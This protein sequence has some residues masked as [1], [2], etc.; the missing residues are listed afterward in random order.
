M[1]S[2]ALIHMRRSQ[3][4][5]KA[6]LFSA[7]GLLAGT[8]SDAVSHYGFFGRYDGP[9]T[10]E[11]CHPGE[12]DQVLGS[13]HYTWRSPNPKLAYPGGGS[14]GMLDRFCALVG[15]SAMLNYY[16]DLAGHQ[17]SSACG[18]CHV[19]N[20]PPFPDSGTGWYSQS[21]IDGLDCL[22]CHAADGHYDMNGD[23]IYD[24]QDENAANRAL[25]T[26]SVTGERYWFQDRSMWAAESVG[27]P[28][29]SGACLRCHEH[30]MGAPDYKR[31]TPYDAAHDVHAAN[32]LLCTDCHLVNSHQ[33]ARGSRVCDMHGWE[34]QDVE[35]DCEQ[36]HTSTPHTPAGS[37]YNQHTAF[38][39]CETCHIPWASGATRRVWGSVLGVTNGPEASV[40]QWHANR[41]VWEPYSAYSE[42]PYGVRPVYRWFNGNASMLA[43]PVNDQTAWDSVYASKST[44]G[45]KIYPFRPIV[46]GMV[47]DRRGLGS[48]PD[49]NPDFTM[50]AA[51][52]AMQ[53][54]LI[55]M[56]FL[57]PSGLNAVERQVLGQYPNL[58]VFDE[59]HY[60]KTGN[61]RESVDIGMGRMGL[62][63]QGSSQIFTTPS[64]QLMALGT[65]LWSG[66]LAGLDLPNN[67]MSPTYVEST[68]PT[69]A[70]GSYISINH[71]IKSGAQSLHCADCHSPNSVLDFGAL[72]YSVARAAYLRG[73]VQIVSCQPRGGGLRLQWT[74]EPGLTYQVWTCTNLEAGNWTVMS[75]SCTATNNTTELQAPASGAPATYYRVEL[76]P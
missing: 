45:A 50:L 7:L 73:M 49:F 47:V 11:A 36:C 39:A 76:L 52:D 48:M 69:Q 17:G 27:E 60:V 67:P 62:L 10:C 38:V 14:H 43:E 22:I 31:G 63:M 59:E 2:D 18:K 30:G 32:G 35:V 15:S 57:R 65:N 64:G 20:A 40:P 16:A 25:L 70:T 12:V 6:A 13:I 29:T 53:W 55:R 42:P 75:S 19:G 54:T 46:N 74:S 28:V 21:Q 41:G 66:Q 5:W 61:V 9:S 37:Q 1:A 8:R 71:A 68:D 33:M 23:G 4:H 24:P 44:P 51:M 3:H 26:N 58:L 56:G 34:R 72:G